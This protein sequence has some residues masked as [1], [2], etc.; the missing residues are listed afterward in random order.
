MLLGKKHAYEI[1]TRS[2]A[3]TQD[4][5]YP[6]GHPNRIEQNS[7]RVD[8]IRTKSKK[9]KKK[10]KTALESSEQARDPN[11]VSIF[12]AET[13]SGNDKS[14]ASDKEIE[15]EPEKYTRSTKSTKE[16]FIANKHGKEKITLGAKTPTFS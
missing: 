15:E 12:N 14:D 11:S 7:Q 13:E 16:D 5:L 6:E 8:D 2:G 4:P 3:T 10:H 1:K 9:K